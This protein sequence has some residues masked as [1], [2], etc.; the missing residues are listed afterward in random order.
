[1]KQLEDRLNEEQ[2]KYLK[3]IKPDYDSIDTYEL[4]EWLVELFQRNGVEDLELNPKQLLLESII[5]IVAEI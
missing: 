5:D 3:E 1:M 4:Y 2:I